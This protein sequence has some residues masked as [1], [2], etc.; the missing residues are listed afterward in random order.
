GWSRRSS[1][2][3]NEAM[4]SASSGALAAAS[5]KNA[6]ASG[7][8]EAG[9]V[10]AIRWVAVISPGA[11]PTTHTNL[12]PPASS[13]AYMLDSVPVG[14]SLGW[15]A[16]ARVILVTP[17]RVDPVVARPLSSIIDHPMPGAATT[18]PPEGAPMS[19]L[20]AFSLAGRVAL[21]PGAGGAIGTAMSL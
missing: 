5:R 18:R 17:G 3:P 9:S 4:P 12:V 14:G 15:A 10:T 7:S 13:P 11:R 21:I 8:V 6:T 20:D 19:V 1:T 16:A 2:G